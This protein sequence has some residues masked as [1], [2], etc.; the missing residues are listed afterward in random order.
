MIRIDFT[1]DVVEVEEDFVLDPLVL[2]IT[3]A[4]HGKEDLCRWHTSLWTRQLI[5]PE[6][7]SSMGATEFRGAFRVRE[8]SLRQGGGTYEVT[9]YVRMGKERHFNLRLEVQNES[10][11]S[12]DDTKLILRVTGSKSTWIY[13]N[14]DP[15]RL[16]EGHTVFGPTLEFTTTTQVAVNEALQVVEPVVEGKVRPTA[17]DRLGEDE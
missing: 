6:V 4:P 11:A 9:S 15:V 3:G 8:R 5:E 13:G 10:A 2:L 7:T 17:W 14:Q 1:E 12:R 16:E